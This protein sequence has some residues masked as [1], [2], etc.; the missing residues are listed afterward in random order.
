VADD[1]KRRGNQGSRKNRDAHAF[2]SRRLQ[3]FEAWTDKAEVPG[4]LA[5]F[6][7]RY[8]ATAIGA[9]LRKQDQR[10]RFQI[11][12]NIVRSADPHQLLALRHG[13][14]FGAG[15]LLEESE[16]EVTARTPLL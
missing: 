12:G 13:T 9:A 11:I 14:Q 10:Y 16:I 15:F 3:A 7:G 2:D 6:Q 5:V 1:P 4:T 8:C